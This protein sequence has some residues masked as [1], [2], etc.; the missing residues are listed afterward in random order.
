MAFLPI[1]LMAVGTVIQLAGAQRQ[2]KAAE[3]EG[4]AA[5]QAEEYKAAQLRQNAG[6]EIA[7]AQRQRDNERRRATLAASRLIAV[8][9]ASGG[10]VTD[11]TVL[12]LIGDIQ[13]EGTYRGLTAIYQGEDKARQL[14]QGAATADYQGT[15][16]EQA[17]RNKASAIKSQA[18]GNALMTGGSLYA[19]YGMPT[20]GTN[21][22]AG[23][24]DSY[25]LFSD[26]GMSDPR[27]G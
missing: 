10:K 12:N 23:A 3:A 7:A 5:R 19:K 27:F 14:N 24:L 4:I 15:I 11:P 2:A 18:V 22:S 9:G 20:G 8:A 1:A 6:Q 21:P 25:E 26:K 16:Y 17:G 13:G